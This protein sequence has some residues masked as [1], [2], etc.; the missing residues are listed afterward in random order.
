MSN[1]CD[2]CK[3]NKYAL[4]ITKNING[5]KSNTH[6]CYQ[7]SL[8]MQ[9]PLFLKSLFATILQIEKTSSYDPGPTCANCDASL[10]DLLKRGKVGC[11][12]CYDTFSVELGAIMDSIQWSLHHKGKIPKQNGKTLIAKKEISDL[13]HELDKAISLEEFEEAA[14]LRDEIKA[15]SAP[16]PTDKPELD[17]KP[18]RENMFLPGFEDPDIFKA[19]LHQAL[20]NGDDFE[21]F[22]DTILT[23]EER[24]RAAEQLNGKPAPTD[25]DSLNQD[26]LLDDTQIDMH[27]HLSNTVAPAPQKKPAP[28]KKAT[29]KPK[30]ETAPKT[31]AKTSGTK[32]TAKAGAETTTKPKTKAKPKTTSTDDPETTS[33]PNPDQV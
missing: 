5:E 10:D 21:T 1:L 22:L 28:K 31:P 18:V 8:E 12:T 4:V 11:A 26:T 20:M 19:A 33:P 15:L 25:S 24:A 3:K 27:E 6:L 2:N 29:P 17:F 13:R 14:R 9:T 30:A 16:K 32:K 23:P 7:C